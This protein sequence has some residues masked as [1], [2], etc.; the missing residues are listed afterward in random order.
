MHIHPH[1]ILWIVCYHVAAC[2]SAYVLDF[3]WAEMMVVMQ[4]AHI[5][6]ESRP[7]AELVMVAV[8]TGLVHIWLN[9]NI[10]EYHP[11]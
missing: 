8:L 11:V 6:L 9:K 3:A 4:R 7:A 10:M 5:Q 2:S 1:Y